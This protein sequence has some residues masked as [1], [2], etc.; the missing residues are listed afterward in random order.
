MS[1]ERISRREAV[2]RVARAG[3]GVYALS[4]LPLLARCAPSLGRPNILFIFTDDH[5]PHA[6]SAYGSKVNRTPNI[7]RIA[8]E[9]VIFLNSFCTNAICAPSRAVVLTGK[10][11][12]ANGKLDNSGEPF[13]MTQPTF[14]KL[15][16]TAG[17]QTAVIGKW[18]LRVDPLGFDHWEVLPGQGRYYNPDFRTAT[19]DVRYE[20]YATDIITDLSLEWLRN[21]RDPERPFLLMS[22]HKAPHRNWMPGPDHLYTYEDVDIPEPDSLFD[23]YANRASPAADTEMTIAEHMFPAYDLKITPPAADNEMDQ[24]FWAVEWDRMTEQ[25][26]AAWDAAYGPRNAAFF[27]ASLE[28]EALVR[29]YYQRYM[30][31]YLRC[32]ASVDDNVGRILDYLDESRLADDTL[33]IYCSDQG[34]FLGEHGWYDK[35]WM[36]EESLRMPFVA[37]WPGGI[38]PGQR[39]PQLIQ[40]IDY[41]PTFIQLAGAE[42][43]TDLHGASLLDLMVGRQPRR[44]RT[45]VY[46]HYYEYPDPHRVAPHYGMR[47]ERHKLVYYYRTR[48]WEL[49]DLEADPSEMRSIHG[50]PT[51]RAILSDLKREL[52]RLRAVYG[53]ATGEDFT[54]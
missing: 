34:F 1:P 37:R 31:D 33:V 6:I 30:K 51:Y 3:A 25:Q 23:D 52:R 42:A 32:I 43:P 40:N 41:A 44:W 36:Y 20:G 4:A 47:T 19:G 16:Q 8:N 14:N 9:G 45:S 26:R 54:E 18:H 10:H 12:H 24:R 35:R 39:V 17:Y 50:D 15:L 5:A 29:Y 21:G 48:E 53:D 38:E 22:Q 13:D 2:S 49:F 46:Y 11:S 27:A 7:D 28:G